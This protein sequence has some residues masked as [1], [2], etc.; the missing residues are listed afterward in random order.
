M[1]RI[2]PVTKKNILY[3]KLSIPQPELGK[4]RE[5]IEEKKANMYVDRILDSF[6]LWKNSLCFLV[7]TLAWLESWDSDVIGCH[8]IFW[9]VLRRDQTT[10]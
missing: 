8:W 4:D 9:T 7:K 3:G 5:K 6:I 10:E 2:F 1:I